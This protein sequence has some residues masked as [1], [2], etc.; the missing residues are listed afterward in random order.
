MFEVQRSAIALLLSDTTKSDRIVAS[1][2]NPIRAY[3]F[4]FVVK[5]QRS[6]IALAF[7]FF[8][9]TGGV[10]YPGAFAAFFGFPGRRRRLIG[11]TL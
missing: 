6:A 4:L 7:P 11:A 9:K 1:T 10:V 2:F 8:W 5:L 3:S